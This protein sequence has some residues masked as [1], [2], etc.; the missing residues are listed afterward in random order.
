MILARVNDSCF[1]VGGVPYRKGHLYPILY[2]ESG[3]IEFRREIAPGYALI[4]PFHYSE[5]IDAT[6]G[7]PFASFND[8]VAWTEANMFFTPIG[9]GA[10]TTLPFMKWLYVKVVPA[11]EDEVAP[12]DTI[13]HSFLGS[14]YLKALY[15]DGVLYGPDDFVHNSGL[16]SVQLNAGAFADG[17]VLLLLKTEDE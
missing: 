5:Y 9:G 10:G 14:G 16:E 3:K 6:T 1:S 12:G 11:A 13:S 17:N 2:V 7:L 4:G 15:K 8:V